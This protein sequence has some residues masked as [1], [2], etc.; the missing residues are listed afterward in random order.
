MKNNKI[1]KKKREDVYS[2]L[3]HKVNV[4]GGKIDPI[5]PKGD[6]TDISDEFLADLIVMRAYLDNVLHK[7]GY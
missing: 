3:Y 6:K 2:N 1:N 5:L 7:F 4:L